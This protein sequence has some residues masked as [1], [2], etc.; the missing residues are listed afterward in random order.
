[1][2]IRRPTFRSEQGVL[3]SFLRLPFHVFPVLSSSSLCSCLSSCSNSRID[4]PLPC[5][6]PYAILAFP[7]C[8]GSMLPHLGLML[9]YVGLSWLQLQPTWPQHAPTWPQLGSTWPQLSP[10]CPQ[11][12]LNLP[13]LGPTWPQHSSNIA[14]LSSNI[15]FWR[16]T[17]HL[18]STKIEANFGIWQNFKN[19]DFAW[20]VCQKQGFREECLS[21]INVSMCQT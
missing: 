13:Q 2:Y 5:G 11:L 15:G 6:P 8:L 20:S 7:F 4:R 14:Q 18:K 10:T 16:P 21:K 3:N 12:G 9:A 19:R 17:W 1:M